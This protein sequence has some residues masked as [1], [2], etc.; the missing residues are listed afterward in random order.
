MLKNVIKLEAHNDTWTTLKGELPG[1]PGT[2]YVGGTFLF[3]IQ[4]PATYPLN[5]PM[6]ICCQIKLKTLL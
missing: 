2:P 1:P 4:I 6:V 3:E 5:P